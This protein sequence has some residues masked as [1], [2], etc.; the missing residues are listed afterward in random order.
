MSEMNGKKSSFMPIWA[1]VC[2]IVALISAIQLWS[3]PKPAPDQQMSLARYVPELEVILNN[4]TNGDS[5]FDPY[6]VQY[7]L[8]PE[9]NWTRSTTFSDTKEMLNSKIV[10]NV[11]VVME[12][13]LK[14]CR[15][16]DVNGK[17]LVRVTNA[18]GVNLVP[19]FTDESTH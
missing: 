4:S 19:V 11:F 3:E 7:R 14:T 2:F 15:V 9:T 10:L 17:V 16:R 6:L 1:T 5:F 18:A 13:D 12:Y 8:L